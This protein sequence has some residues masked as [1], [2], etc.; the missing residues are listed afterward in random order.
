MKQASDLIAAQ[1]TN[2]RQLIAELRPAALA[3]LGLT[4]PLH[5]LARRCEQLSGIPVTL[6][7]SL[8]YADGVASSRLLPDVE[9]AVY[10]V[11]Q[12][13]L[14]NIRR[15]STATRI[16]VTVIEDDDAVVAEISDNGQGFDADRASGFGLSGMVERAEIAQGTLD[17]LP[18]GLDGRGTTIRL[19]VPARHR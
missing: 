13:A 17:V 2:L 7:V 15:H 5:A 3:D 19:V 16:V 11:V 9:L 12:E 6:H 1:I 14:T 10:R 18:T 8:R 4:P